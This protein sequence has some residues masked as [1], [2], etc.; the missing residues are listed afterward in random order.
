MAD[1]FKEIKSLAYL[2]KED[3]HFADFVYQLEDFDTYEPRNSGMVK[4]ALSKNSSQGFLE[5]AVDFLVKNKIL[6]VK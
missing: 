3:G 2:K 5:G 4:I 6:A 1:L